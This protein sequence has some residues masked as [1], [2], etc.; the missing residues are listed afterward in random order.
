MMMDD[1]TR[2]ES[3]EMAVKR[4]AALIRVLERKQLTPETFI[5]PVAHFESE[6]DY[7]FFQMMTQDSVMLVMDYTTWRHYNF[8]VQFGLERRGWK[9]Q[10]VPIRRREFDAKVQEWDATR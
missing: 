4:V 6:L 1:A 8:L 5:I 7:G 3:V 9:T 2:L 10:Q